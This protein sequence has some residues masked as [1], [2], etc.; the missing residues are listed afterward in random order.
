M[1][2]KTLWEQTLEPL[3]GR[4]DSADYETWIKPMK[5]ICAGENGV[6]ISVPNRMFAAWVEENFSWSQRAENLEIEL[7]KLRGSP[8]VVPRRG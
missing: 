1:N 2:L 7:A 6:E 5:P 8:R 4:L 3:R